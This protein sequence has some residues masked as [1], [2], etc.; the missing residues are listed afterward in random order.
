VVMLQRKPH[1]EAVEPGCGCEQCRSWPEA[2]GEMM[3]RG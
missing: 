3:P 1:I 2:V